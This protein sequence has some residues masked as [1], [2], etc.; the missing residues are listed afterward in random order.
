LKLLHE[1]IDLVSIIK[2][3]VNDFSSLSKRRRRENENQ[4]SYISFL[5]N[6]PR[7]TAYGD[8]TRLEQVVR[9]L[10]TNALNYTM[11]GSIT[12][13]LHKDNSSNEWVVSV[14]DTGPGIDPNI[15]PRLF[16][17]FVTNSQDVYSIGLGLY[18]SKKIIEAQGGKI[19]AENNKG[20]NGA[21]F[22]FALPCAR[23]GR[24]KEAETYLV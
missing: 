7:A 14:K 5:C 19:W 10:L 23:R 3:V 17:K 11:D 20:S 2:S 22:S 16:T 24:V 8:R 1:L 6:Y 15:F 9:N 4:K 12:V 21:T 13:S 18:I